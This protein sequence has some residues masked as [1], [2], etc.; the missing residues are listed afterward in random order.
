MPIILSAGMDF[1]MSIIMLSIGES[2][3]GCRPHSRTVRG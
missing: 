3:R 2:S 1:I